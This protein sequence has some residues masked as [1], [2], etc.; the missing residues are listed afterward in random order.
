[1]R[2]FI[3]WVVA[4]STVAPVAAEDTLISP[5]RDQTTNEIRGLSEKEISELREGRGMGLARAAEM[6]GYP[7]PRHVL[8][9]VREGRLHLSPEQAQAVERL[10]D[11]MGL[12]AKRLGDMILKEERALEEE[13]RKGTIS[14]AALQRSVTRIAA[15][16]GQLRAVH[17]RTHLEMRPVLSEQ[18]IQHYNQL[19]GYGASSSQEHKH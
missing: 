1:M 5:Y 13:F 7:G 15:L 11:D 17:L 14:E 12:K 10:F 8:D 6:N 4:L 3:A 16:Q 9:A 18:Q 2:F 19:R